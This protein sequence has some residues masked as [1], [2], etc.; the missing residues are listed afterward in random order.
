M[1]YVNTWCWYLMYIR[2]RNVCCS[3]KELKELGSFFVIFYGF[4]ENKG[5]VRTRV[6]CGGLHEFSC[7]HWLIKKA[8]SG[9]I[10][11]DRKNECLSA[12]LSLLL[13]LSVT[14]TVPGSRIYSIVRSIL[15]Y[16]HDKV[17]HSESVVLDYSSGKSYSILKCHHIITERGV[18]ILQVIR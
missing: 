5:R 3:N 8:F 6:N 11:F 2:I 9:R 15:Q 14:I 16:T 4:P 18:E 1:Y 7:L 12:A 17:A 13:S 10:N